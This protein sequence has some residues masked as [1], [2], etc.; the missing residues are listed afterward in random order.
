[1]LKR[2]MTSLLFAFTF[3]LVSSSKTSAQTIPFDTTGGIQLH[4]TYR[5]GN[6]DV[7]YTEVESAMYQY[8]TTTNCDAGSVVVNGLQPGQKYKFQINQN[9]GAWSRAVVGTAKVLPTSMQP[10]TTPFLSNDNGDGSVHLMWSNR[11]GSCFIKYTEADQKNYKYSTVANC[12]DGQ[13]FINALVTGRTYKFSLSQD[14]VTWSRPT[15]AVAKHSEVMNAATSQ[16]TSG[17]ARTGSVKLVWNYRGSTCSVR[18]NEAGL[19]GY[20]YSTSAGC[21]EGQVVINGLVSGHQYRFQ[22]MPEGASQWSKAVVATA[23]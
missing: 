18:Y 16:I 19:K 2:V 17:A 15:F 22:V 23:R 14:N 6:C 9:N 1:M 12:E 7:R 13:V 8:H 11:G 3:F 10:S 21:D 20:K 4:W 5:S